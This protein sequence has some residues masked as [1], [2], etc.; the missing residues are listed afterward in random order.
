MEKIGMSGRNLIYSEYLVHIGSS[1]MGIVTHE[2]RLKDCL[3]PYQSEQVK[4]FVSHLIPKRL[5][6]FQ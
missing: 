3:Q 5:R 2:C 1:G 6:N 4:S